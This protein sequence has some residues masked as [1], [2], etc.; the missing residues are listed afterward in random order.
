[1]DIKLSMKYVLAALLIAIFSVTATNVLAK[2]YPT[3]A[4]N[5]VIPFG[6]GGESDITAR[7]Q[8]PFFKK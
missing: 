3:K 7:H 5:Y 6:P 1:M 4:V 2:D 8:Q